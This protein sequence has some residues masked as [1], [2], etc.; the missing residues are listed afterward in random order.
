MPTGGTSTRL[1]SGPNTV[2]GSRIAGRLKTAWTIDKWPKD[3]RGFNPVWRSL[4]F[5][6]LWARRGQVS[7]YRAQHSMCIDR[8]C[9]VPTGIRECCLYCVYPALACRLLD[10]QYAAGRSWALLRLSLRRHAGKAWWFRNVSVELSNLMA[11]ASDA[12][13]ALIGT[14]ELSRGDYE[15]ATE[16]KRFCDELRPRRTAIF[17]RRYLA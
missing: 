10:R 14:S 8:S 3:K 5:R 13:G 7:G 9:R 6:R 1:R 11:R 4:W 16:E 12:G 17:H 15:S 2:S